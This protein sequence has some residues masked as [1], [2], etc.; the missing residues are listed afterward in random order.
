[1]QVAY[2]WSLNKDYLLGNN[3]C[4]FRYNLI[5]CMLEKTQAEYLQ[6]HE[7]GSLIGWVSEGIQAR[8]IDARYHSS[9]ILIW[10]KLAQTLNF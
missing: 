2:W 9:A 8:L 10:S 3:A 5:A 1:M 4:H 7:N 6:S